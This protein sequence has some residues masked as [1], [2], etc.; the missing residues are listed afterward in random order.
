[1]LLQEVI[2]SLYSKCQRLIA[3]ELEVLLLPSPATL[4]LATR[5]LTSWH[6]C[7]LKMPLNCCYIPLGGEIQYPF[8]GWQSYRGKSVIFLSNWKKR[9]RERPIFGISTCKSISFARK[10]RLISM[11]NLREFVVSLQALLDCFSCQNYIFAIICVS[12]K[13]YR[14]KG[15][16]WM[17]FET[18]SFS[19]V[20]K[21]IPNLQI[22]VGMWFPVFSLHM[23]S[24]T[25]NRSNAR[26]LFFLSF[27]LFFFPP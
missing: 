20:R 17:R 19:P 2:P 14:N 16:I 12:S 23:S 21:V 27:F 26:G 1:M 22:N 9:K 25:P 15:N 13:I 24:Q 10:P 6:Q 11:P 5:P 7:T 18:T 4:Q 8:G 3:C